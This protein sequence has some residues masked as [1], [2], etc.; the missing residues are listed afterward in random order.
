MKI[1]DALLCVNCDEV[2]SS[3]EY[4]QCPRCTSK[5]SLSLYKILNRRAEDGN[6]RPEPL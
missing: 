4:M 1:D 2:Y 5:M 3:S 6:K